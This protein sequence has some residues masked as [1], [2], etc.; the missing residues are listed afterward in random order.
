MG[1]SEDEGEEGEASGMHGDLCDVSHQ[2]MQAVLL[3]NCNEDS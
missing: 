1:N 3:F 2:T